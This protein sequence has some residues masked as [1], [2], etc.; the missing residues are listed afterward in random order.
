[1]KFLIILVYL[2][3]Q[4]NN[5]Q[6]ILE[7]TT[8]KQEIILD[9]NYTFEEAIK[10]IEIP[11]SISKQL[12]LISVEYYSFD[13]RLHKGQ[14]VVNKKA[15]KDIEE[16]FNFIKESKFP[17]AKVIP[18]VKFN[19]DDDASMNDNNT[20]A[21]NYRK[22]KGSKVLSAHSYGMAIDINPL[23][24]PHIKGKV[25]Q[26]AQGKYN[27]NASGTIIRDSKLVKEF[28]KRGWQWGGRWKSSKDY[29]HFEKKN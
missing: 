29:Q 24:N 4:T 15:A 27:V 12:T 1:M 20:V 23:Q 22:V 17:I 14:L 7:K 2:F 3:I 6:I 8:H 19:W 25:I 21:F 18:A 5:F 10:G 9:C 28:V 26:P 11:N 13:D 16:I